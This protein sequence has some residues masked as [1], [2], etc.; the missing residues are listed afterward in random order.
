MCLGPLEIKI[1]IQD[2]LPRHLPHF[3]QLRNWQPLVV[4]GIQSKRC[5][6][7]GRSVQEVDRVPSRTRWVA[8]RDA[9]KKLAP[10][11]VIGDVRQAPKIAKGVHVSLEDHSHGSFVV[12]G[13][14]SR[15]DCL[16]PRSA[17]K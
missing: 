17:V 14:P 6:L 3:G 4:G 16:Q 5:E 10:E 15:R 9:E 11:S 12:D 2:F 8:F 7:C 13:R 1:E